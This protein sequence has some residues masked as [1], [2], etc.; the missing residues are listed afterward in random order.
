MVALSPNFAVLA[1]LSALAAT[2]LAPVNGVAI[3]S[4]PHRSQPDRNSDG[5]V[6]FDKHRS[7]SSP[8]AQGQSAS[9]EA[10]A[11]DSDLPA[12]P[13]PLPGLSRRLKYNADGQP[14]FKVGS[15]A[16]VA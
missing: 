11:V 12:L 9:S 5:A 15:I 6:K 4:A 1:S 16:V 10:D 2:V 7:G 13:I 8:S 14:L 3:P